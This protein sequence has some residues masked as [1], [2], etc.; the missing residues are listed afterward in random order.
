MPQFLTRSAVRLLEAALDSLSL[1]MT[2]AAAPV[3][4][5]PKSADSAFATVA[6]MTG[7]AAEQVLS[8]ILIQVDG[9]SA[10]LTPDGKFKT[11]GHVL[12]DVRRILTAPPVAR[13]A[14]LT[15]GLQE[16]VRH[17]QDL[18]G[19]LERFTLLAAQRAGALHGGLGVSREVALHSVRAVHGFISLL[20]KSAKIKPYIS[21]MPSMPEAPT[22]PYLILDELVAR[23]AS[24]ETTPQKGAIL[25]QL[26]LVL[27]EVPADAP[28]WLEAFERVMIVPTERDVSVLMT[29]LQAA[30]P[31]RFS[32]LTGGGRAINV[33]VSRSLAAL[34]VELQSLRS[35]F[36]NIADQIG[37]DIANANGRL[38]QN[39]LHLP[40]D[41]II[42]SLFAMPERQFEEAFGGSVLT[43]HIAW[44]FIASALGLRNGTP[45]PYW[46][47]V[48]RVQDLGQLRTLLQRAARVGQRGTLM[49][50]ITDEAIVG[51]N[52]IER[53]KPLPSNHPLFVECANRSN[54]AAVAAASLPDAVERAINSGRRSIPER[55]RE[56]VLDL[57]T[58]FGTAGEAWAALE[59]DPAQGRGAAD[60]RAY[61]GRMLACSTTSPN[62]VA[63]LASVCMDPTL[64]NAHTAARKALRLIDATTHGPSM[65]FE[66]NE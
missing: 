13:A 56:A 22:E 43:A 46:F 35:E 59:A 17:R 50:K 3:R 42:A 16:P 57:S 36:T 55:A 62:D 18:L 54:S 9:D 19:Y 41:R 60:S 2:A 40:P 23:L 30:Q 1:A 26:F 6:G 39:T 10:A 28:D 27:P 21:A 32:R 65:D 38:N 58:G 11:A 12:S 52:A 8:A 24:A 47:L 15:A 66:E 37:G 4:H 48:R 29:T 25:R 61:W 51:I 7:V 31:A 53:S 49:Q 63:F 20:G 33:S 5:T 64:S 14:F 44:A 45:W 34:P